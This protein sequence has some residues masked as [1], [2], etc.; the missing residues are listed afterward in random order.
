[1]AC[2]RTNGKGN[3]T[4]A[5]KVLIDLNGSGLML[6]HMLHC[7]GRIMEQFAIS[8]F[9]HGLFQINELV[10]HLLVKQYIHELIIIS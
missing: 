5:F 4:C 1:M 9:K 6:V 7:A 3:C 10:R 2:E 8:S